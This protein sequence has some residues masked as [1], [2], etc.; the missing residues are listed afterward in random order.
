MTAVG[1]RKCG[2]DGCNA[3]EF[4][5]SG[6]CL[7]HKGGTSDEKIPVILGKPGVS[8]VK[9]LFDNI[10]RTEIWWIPI[11]P[12]VY[13]PILLLAF[14]HIADVE[15]GD[16]APYFLYELVYLLVWLFVMPVFLTP[17]ILPVYALY[18]VRINRR[19]RENGASNILLTMF[20]I[21]SIAPTA[22]GFLLFWVWASAQGA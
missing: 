8:G 15:L 17:V 5:T 19:R 4:R 12:L 13:P 3:L 2:F 7:R 22:I 11:I 6:Y 20:H 14:P 18:L 1:E 16:A 9:P 10:G 21:I